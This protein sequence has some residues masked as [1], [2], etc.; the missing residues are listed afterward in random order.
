MSRRSGAGFTLIETV[1]VIV[2]VGLLGGIVGPLMVGAAD[3]YA[4]AR[5]GRRAVEDASFALDRIV[6]LLRE[7]P[8]GDAPGTPA[9]S[10]ITPEAFSFADGTQVIWADDEL[11]FQ[12]GA[13]PLSPLC[14]KVTAFEVRYLRGDGLPLDAGAGDDASD[15][16]RVEVRLVADGQDLRTCVYLRLRAEES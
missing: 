2:I 7:S 5:D 4:G 6:R 16:R 9:F 10:K 13:G 12:Q 8:E 11:L 1:A 15:V 3:A 14:R